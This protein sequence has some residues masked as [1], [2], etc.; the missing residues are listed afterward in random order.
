SAYDRAMANKHTGYGVSG[1]YKLANQG[2][3]G[4]VKAAE[5]AR[6]AGK[7]IPA[8]PFHGPSIIEKMEEAARWATEHV[9]SLWKT[10]Y[11]KHAPEGGWSPLA[12]PWKFRSDVG[13]GITLRGFQPFVDQANGADKLSGVIHWVKTSNPRGEISRADIEEA[14]D[15][16]Y[17][18]TLNDSPLGRGG[19]LFRVVLDRSGP[20]LH[21]RVEQM[22]PG[23]WGA[24][25]FGADV[26]PVQGANPVELFF[27]LIKK[28]RIVKD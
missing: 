8:S 17:Y 3:Q 9:D 13:P 4:W 23:G 28:D 20:A 22:L 6:A 11:V 25:T 12:A 2:Y 27:G 26:T 1:W 21:A 19:T 24:P 14:P 5:T 7:P 16:A 18:T 10:L 15:T